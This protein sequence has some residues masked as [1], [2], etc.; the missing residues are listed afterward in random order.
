MFMLVIGKVSARDMTTDS[1]SQL[2]SLPSEKFSGTRAANS[3]FVSSNYVP[4]VIIIC[5]GNRVSMTKDT[6][7]IPYILIYPRSSINDTIKKYTGNV[8]SKIEEI[9][10]AQPSQVIGALD[11]SPFIGLKTLILVGDDHDQIDSVN[12]SF[13]KCPQLKTIISSYVWLNSFD[14]LDVTHNEKEAYRRFRKYIQATRS[15]I[16]LKVVNTVKYHE[17]GWGKEF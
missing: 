4:R 17:L 7:F 8:S 6:I 15:D 13:F 11:F 5:Y 14:N 10:I 9:F 3:Q 1:F 2:N 12:Y 16:K